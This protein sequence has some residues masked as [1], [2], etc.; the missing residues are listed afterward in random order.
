MLKN[1]NPFDPYASEPVLKNTDDENLN[2]PDNRTH[3]MSI[4]SVTDLVMND[5]FYVNKH[6]IDRGYSFCCFFED[7]NAI[8]ELQDV[9]NGF[10]AAK[11]GEPS[12]I[13]SSL[14]AQNTSSYM[15]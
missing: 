7:D 11:I 15:E 12:P 6:S 8:K 1:S 2:D 13:M 9:F 14:I 10:E 5:G 4:T 3:G